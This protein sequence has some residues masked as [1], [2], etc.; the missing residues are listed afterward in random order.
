MWE[1]GQTETRGGAVEGGGRGRWGGGGQ[2]LWACGS[3]SLA[4][5]RYGKQ[6]QLGAED[7][8]FGRLLEMLFGEGKFK[9]VFGPVLDIFKSVCHVL[10]CLRCQVHNVYLQYDVGG[11]GRRVGQGTPTPHPLHRT[12]PPPIYR[13]P[14]TAPLSRSATLP[15]PH[16]S[17]PSPPLWIRMAGCSFFRVPSH[18]STVEHSWPWAATVVHLISYEDGFNPPPPSGPVLVHHP[19]CEAQ[20]ARNRED[21]V[22]LWWSGHAALLTPVPLTF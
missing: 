16:T 9:D 18:G 11:L 12:P 7:S 3:P 19:P 5:P 1:P 14:S 6:E 4:W 20:C 17:L 2:L 8:A 15:K 21:I 10:L 22:S 13:P